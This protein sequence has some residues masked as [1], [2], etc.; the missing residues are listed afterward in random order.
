MS[1]VERAAAAIHGL[2]RKGL[3][4]AVARITRINASQPTL[5]GPVSIS[6]LSVRLFGEVEE[7]GWSGAFLAEVSS[8]GQTASSFVG[9]SVKVEAIGDL[10]IVAYTINGS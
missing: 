7:C 8:S 10:L 3:L 6:N 1:G 5:N 2:H 9:R 4:P